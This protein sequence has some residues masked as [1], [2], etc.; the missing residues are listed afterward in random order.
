MGATSPYLITLSEKDRKALEATAARY[1]AP[2][3]DVI[4]AKI[5]LFAA[6][7]MENTEI[8]SRLGVSRQLVVHWRKRFFEEGVS[9]LEERQRSGRPRRFP[10]QRHD[11][12]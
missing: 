11:R 5:V 6:E 10:P 8:A 9:G 4:R 12:G 7:G 1:T 3:R 2:F